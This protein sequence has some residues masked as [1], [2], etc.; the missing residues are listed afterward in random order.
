MRKRLKPREGKAPEY[1]MLGTSGGFKGKYKKVRGPMDCHDA[2]KFLM[3]QRK[4]GRRGIKNIRYK[5]GCYLYQRFDKK[6]YSDTY[7]P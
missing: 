7:T 3:L 5:S 1:L 4:K 2:R 6:R